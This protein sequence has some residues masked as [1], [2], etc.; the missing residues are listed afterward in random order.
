MKGHKWSSLQK[1][2]IEN[3]QGL[4]LNSREHQHLSDEKPIGEDEERTERSRR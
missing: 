2:F 1:V 4:G 3:E